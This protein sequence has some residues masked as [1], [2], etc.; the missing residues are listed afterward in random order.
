M[1]S[2]ESLW[3]WLE[4]RPSRTAVM[5]EWRRAAGGALPAVEPM[6]K[7][8]DRPATSYPN[9]RPHGRPLKVVHHN[10]G[11]VVAFDEE[12]WQNRLNLSPA[13]VVLHQ[14]DLRALR[15]AVCGALDGV[16]IVK[17]PVDQSATRIQIGNWE[18]KKAAS[19]PVYLLLCASRNALH[20]QVL[21]LRHQCRHPGA[22]LLT[23]SRVNWNDTI[24]ATARSGKMLLVPIC[25]IV[26]SSGG[27]LAETESWEQYLQAFAQMVRLTLPSNYRN[28]RPNVRRAPLM[29]KVDKVRRALVDHIRSA[30]DGVIA[31]IDAGAGTRLVSFLTK[32]ELAKLADLEPYHVTRCFQADPQLERLYHIANDPEELLRFGK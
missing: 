12:D 15:K 5:A 16:N 17:T 21:E 3:R 13:E 4:S 8:L 27:N 1:S 26:K 11:S 29:A 32:S 23:P 9:P 2:P 28:K 22:I 10:D 25:E 18:P 14:L 24:E 30:R 6:L 19:F 7:P 20:Q 31:G